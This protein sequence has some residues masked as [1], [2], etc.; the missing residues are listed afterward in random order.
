[1]QH[2]SHDYQDEANNKRTYDSPN[3]LIVRHLAAALWDFLGGTSSGNIAII[4][5]KGVSGAFSVTNNLQ[6]VKS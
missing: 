6:V 1:M 2:Y 3:N 4:R 5:A